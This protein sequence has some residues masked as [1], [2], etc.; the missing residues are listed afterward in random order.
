MACVLYDLTTGKFLKSS[1]YDHKTNG[2]APYFLALW[3]YFME[4]MPDFA[5]TFTGRNSFADT[6]S[7]AGNAPKKSR[8]VSTQ[9]VRHFS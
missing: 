1:G 6:A 4:S 5:P 3:N 9:L 2:S 7:R 8:L